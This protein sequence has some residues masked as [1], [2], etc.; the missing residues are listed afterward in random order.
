MEVYIRLTKRKSYRS[1]RMILRLRWHESG[2]Q[3]TCSSW[4]L[5]D[6]RARSTR[7]RGTHQG[8]Q[9]KSH[10]SQRRSAVCMAA[11]LG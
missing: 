1:K 2:Q 3:W 6:K 10:Q 5:N 4:Y 7:H 11:R 9:K 8:C